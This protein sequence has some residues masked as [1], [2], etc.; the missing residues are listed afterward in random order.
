[1]IAI[2]ATLAVGFILAYILLRLSADSTPQS[3]A[4]RRANSQA[5]VGL[6]RH[7]F[8][9]DFSKNARVDVAMICVKVSRHAVIYKEPAIR[10]RPELIDRIGT[11]FDENVYPLNVSALAP[12]ALKGL[13]GETRTTILLLAES[14]G[15]S[16]DGKK[17]ALAGYYSSE[18]EQLRAYRSESNQAK[19]VHVFVGQ[20]DVD[21][22]DVVDTVAHETRHLT[23]WAET[24]NNVGMAISALFALATVI[25]LYLGLSHIYRRS[26]AA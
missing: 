1:M 8:V 24:R 4:L 25:T 6:S 5:K 21:E 13:S 14:R 11:E 9:Y 22:D 12:P 7:F 16:V 15:R 17:S 23:N 3:A 20:F 26:F 18:N 19:I 2:A 10:L